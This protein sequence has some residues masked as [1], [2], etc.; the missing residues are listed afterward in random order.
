MS[1]NKDLQK[2][3]MLKDK[4]AA[5]QATWYRHILTLACAGLALL[6]GLTP[7]VP[8]GCA[9]FFLACTWFFLGLGIIAGGAATY[10]EVNLANKISHQFHKALLQ[11][12][13]DGTNLSATPLISANANKIFSLAKPVML[14]SLIIAVINLVC[15]SIITTLSI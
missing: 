7:K 2:F 1:I 10:L 15:A 4:R 5:V 11:S 8:H 9:Q 6:S 14:I 3:A 13:E 12:L